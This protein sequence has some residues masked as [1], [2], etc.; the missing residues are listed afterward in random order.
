VELKGS[1]MNQD[2]QQLGR[3]AL[4]LNAPADAEL[5]E[6]FLATRDEGA[7][8]VLVRRH[9]PMVL[10][11]CRRILR[12]PQDAE[13]AFQATFLVLVRKVDSIAPREMLGNWLYGVANQTAR[14]ARAMGERRRAREGQAADT[15][16]PASAESR[17]PLWRELRPVIDEELSRLPAKYRAPLV[18]CDIEEMSYRQAAGQLGWPEGTVAGRL[19]RARAMLA[20]RLTRRGVT[21]SAAALP[22]LL[23][24]NAA[25]GP[26]PAAL[27]LP[28]SEAAG[29]L[30][31]SQPMAGVVS[32]QVILLTE[33]VV[34]AMTLTKLKLT[35]V[36]L[37]GVCLV[38]AGA[39]AGGSENPPESPQPPAKKA[40]LKA[41]PKGQVEKGANN[42]EGNGNGGK[43]APVPPRPKKFEVRL[44]KARWDDVIDWY[45][46]ISGL[47]CVTNVRP[48]GVFTCIPPEGKQF[49]L[50]EVTDL[51]NEGLTQQK[52]ILI[53]RENT[54]I[55]HP[56]DEKLDATLVAHVKLS[57]LDA[58]AKSALVEVEIPVGEL[59]LAD[60]APDIRALLSPFG[61]IV[62]ARGKKLVV[63]DTAGNVRRIAK[64]LEV[65]GQNEGDK[66]K[67]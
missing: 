26:V 30:A 22:V 34:K 25:A 54:F 43:A 21:L 12:C 11:V 14:K 50:A 62:Y 29:L 61:R 3:F 65:G 64:I 33:G 6:R 18:L 38:V 60:A 32:A 55:I 59:N 9:G 46:K 63:L 24:Q 47:T 16:E 4:D 51:I 8:E 57:D 41:A 36:V 67:P 56:S 52:F 53:P 37:L 2:M 66:K 28:T 45:T 44:E 58:W 13:D 19:A 31:A 42:Q 39:L 5:I 35:A 10:G 23:S 7:F 15:P 27:L 20:Q 40:E 48:T 49:T 1:A 17:E